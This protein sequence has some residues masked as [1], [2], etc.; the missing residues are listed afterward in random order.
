MADW[1]SF[2]QSLQHGRPCWQFCCGWRGS[3]KELPTELHT[4]RNW[5][6]RL[7]GSGSPSWLLQAKANQI[8]WELSCQSLWG[9]L[10][11]IFFIIFI[12]ICVSGIKCSCSC[13]LN[14]QKIISVVGLYLWTWSEQKRHWSA[15]YQR[16][17][18]NTSFVVRSSQTCSLV[19]A[20]AGKIATCC[21]T[22]TNIPVT[23]N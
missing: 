10:L 15:M 9:G 23:A 21:K 22:N 17:F 8:G 2:F 12:L 5:L 11:L 14:P 4:R 19:Y 16:I 6:T 1:I 7:G 13:Q 18:T 3:R 20:S